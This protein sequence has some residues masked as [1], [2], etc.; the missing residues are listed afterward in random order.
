MYFDSR[1]WAFTSGLRDRIAGAVLI[2]L[3]ST[4][5][6]IARLALLGWLIAAAI[7]GKPLDVLVELAVAVAAVMGLRALLDYWR[8]LIADRTA[9]A[10][11]LKLRTRLYDHLMALG[12]AYLAGAR[13][14]DLLVTV[15]DAIEQLHTYF[16]RYL[17]Q[18]FVALVTP[19]GIF[20]FLA[21]LD[22]PVALVMLVAAMVALFAPSALHRTSQKSA[23]ER[24]R[25][26]KDF[27][28]EFLDSLQGLATL[29][30]FGQ[31]E[32][33]GR[34]IGEKAR[35]LYRATQWVV[36]TSVATRGVTD[37][38]VALG[39]AGAL[40]LGA[41]RVLDGSLAF[42][43]LVVVLML[44]VEVFRPFRELR[45]LLHT[46]MLGQAAA[47]AMLGLL[48]RTP[49]IEDAQSASSNERSLAPTIAFEKV[50]FAYAGGRGAAHRDLDF[51][52]AAGERVALVGPSGSGKSTVLKLLLRF[53]DPQT[54]RVLVGGEDVRSLGFAALRRHIAVVGQDTYLFHGTVEDNLRVA[55][56]EASW[57]EIE[58]AVAAA[59]AREFIG[60]LPQGYQTVI[61]ERGLKLSGGQRQRIAIARALLRDAPIL[62][63]DEA[64]SSV[65]AENEAIIQDAL[66]RLMQGRTTLIFAH[67]LSSVIGSDRILVLDHGRVVESGKHGELMAAR[68]PYW[69]LM[70]EQARGDDRMTA[71]TIGATPADADAVPPDTQPAAAPDEAADSVLKPAKIGWLRVL[72]DLL[73][74]VRPWRG[75]LGV[76][77]GLGIARV[78]AFV[79]VGVLGALVIP[80]LKAGSPLQ[81]LVI[82]LIVLAPIAG[83]VHW[84]ESW[85]AHDVA[86]RLLAEMRIQLYEK[87]DR[88]APAYLLRRRTGDLVALAAHDVELV[89]YF[90]AH[91]LAP[92]FVAVLV[93]TAVLAALAWLHPW[94][95]V[96]L[97]PFLLY[98]AVA[99]VLLRR[100]IDELGAAS[101]RASGRLTAHAVDTIQGVGEIAAFQLETRRRDDMVTLVKEAGRLRLKFLA[102]L[103]RQSVVLDLLTTLG[104][105]AVVIVGAMLAGQGSLNPTMLPLAALIAMSAF[106]PVSEIAQVGRQLADTLGAAERLSA[107]HDEPVPITD[108][109]LSAVPAPVGVAAVALDHV[110]FSYPGLKRRVLDDVTFAVPAG[111]TTAIVGPSGAGKTTIAHLLLR[112]WD[113]H[114]GV[115]RFSGID[116]RELTLDALRRQISLVAQ[117]TYL[118]NADLATNIRMAKPESNDEELQ[119]A[120]QRAALADFVAGLPQGLAT[121]VGERGLQL[122]GGQRQRVAIARALLK[123]SPIL[124]LDEATS[125]L[126]ALSERAVRHALDELKR[127]RTT[128]VIAH[129]LSTIRD[130]Q[131][132]VVLDGGGVRES[133]S[134]AALL[135]AG[136]LYARLVAR[137]SDAVRAAE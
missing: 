41:Y 86:Y 17:P 12:P 32:A 30:A 55:K 76:V 61:G 75:V 21:W 90:F 63:L 83:L 42:S 49:A 77:L 105:L 8:A 14:G 43:T 132:I 39:A 97:L 27:S 78:V 37:T 57:D 102:D 13:T 40:A 71:Q 10:V 60:R 88:L 107:V 46:G 70:R 18:L 117:D 126:D 36:A 93:P 44:G 133:G 112:F 82:A 69:E 84:L 118:F 109:S 15:T 129:R 108:G 130:A 33:R 3:L 34:E 81:G 65:D 67:R 5:A 87:L 38:A 20:A 9:M 121:P 131:Q 4:V 95:A 47:E 127:D 106:L 73:G 6:G 58:R 48:A 99:P 120:I 31:S 122:S 53:H 26:H 1:L 114:Q 22:L 119:R 74:L 116:A 80:A 23:V 111:T 19:I 62:V 45:D 113:P 123:D 136:G 68:G 91:T 128:I 124:V 56:P 85:L 7:E 51:K 100:R 50:T 89:E 29:K 98:A 79:G 134:H 115:V 135:A 24:S 25:A 16:G 66:D 72:G 125:H 110:A 137:Q 96:T 104:A 94:L 35:N 59:N 64:L 54:G 2:G 92:A 101:R 11:Q 28:A 103:A 52:V